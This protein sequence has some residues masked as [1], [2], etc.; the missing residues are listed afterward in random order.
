MALSI[1]RRSAALVGLVVAMTVWGSTF[2]VTKA[3]MREFPPLTLAFLRFAL[4]ALALLALGQSLSA[5]RNP[6]VERGR[7][8]RYTLQLALAGILVSFIP[9][10]YDAAARNQYRSQPARELEAALKQ[11]SAAALTSRGEIPA[12]VNAAELEAT[13]LLSEDSRRWLANSRIQLQA[14]A[15]RTT[16]S[17]EVRYVRTEVSFPSGSRLR[18]L[19]TVP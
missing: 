2:V 16:R 1:S 9:S 10:A 13:G 4:A 12:A 3:V 8:V 15:P 14:S 11:I 7:I 6:Q 18:M 5:F 19:Y 17:G